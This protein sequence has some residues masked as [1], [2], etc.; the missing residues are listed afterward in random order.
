MKKMIATSVVL[1]ALG[2]LGG[3]SALAQGV[4]GGSQNIGLVTMNAQNGSG[5]SGTATLSEENS[6]L[7]VTL[8]LTNGPSG[9]QP[10]HIHKGTCAALDPNPL[11]PLASVVDGK[12]V[13]TFSD[14]TLAQLMSGE[15]AINVHKSATEAST[16]VSCGDLTQMARAGGTNPGAVGMPATGSANQTALPVLLGLLALGLVFTGVRM[17]RRVR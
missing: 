17:A 9:P 5:E 2:V 4:V 11:Y 3:G 6:Q 7:T 8:D 10:A 15:Y 12:S 16:Y 14:V 1:M 13:T